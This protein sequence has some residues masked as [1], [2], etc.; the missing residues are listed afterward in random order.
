MFMFH[1]RRQARRIRAT[2]ERQN[3]A[4]VAGVTLF[5]LLIATGFWT[6]PTP[7]EPGLEARG[8]LQAVAEPP[9]RRG[10]HG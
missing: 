5:P 9:A 10:D 2:A 7:R 4:I 1:L 3:V 6:S 8:G